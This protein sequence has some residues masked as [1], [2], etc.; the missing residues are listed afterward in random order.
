MAEISDRPPLKA[1]YRCGRIVVRFSL[2]RGACSDRADCCAA[3]MIARANGD[4]EFIR[5]VERGLSESL[6]RQETPVAEEHVTR[7]ERRIIHDVKRGHG[8]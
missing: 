4:T 2:D 1:C 8:N 3:A 5:G 6:K 7:H